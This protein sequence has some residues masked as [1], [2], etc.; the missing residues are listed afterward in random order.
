MNKKILLLLIPLFFGIF[1]FNS[2]TE[3][4]V[5]HGTYDGVGGGCSYGEVPKVFGDVFFN[6][7]W[8]Q[9]SVYQH[10]FHENHEVIDN[11]WRCIGKMCEE[12]GEERY[13]ETK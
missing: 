3:H 13:V 2:P 6:K 10:F 9:C 7:I 8:H 4:Y 1:W 5:V 11:Q 12:L